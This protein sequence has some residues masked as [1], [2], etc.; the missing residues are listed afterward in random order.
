MKEIS[1]NDSSLDI[2][3][4]QKF[5]ESNEADVYYGYYQG[6]PIVFKKF[7]T[8]RVIDN[9]VKKIKILKER[10]KNTDNVVTADA[11]VYNHNNIIGYIMPF[12]YGTILIDSPIQNKK[13]S[14]ELLKQLS[15]DIKELHKYNIVLSDYENNTIITPDKKLIFIDHDNFGI[16]DLIIDSENKFLRYYKKHIKHID[17]H[18]DDY[19]MNLLTLATFKKIAF[20]YIDLYISVKKDK[21]IFKDEEINKIIQNT[22]NLNSTYNEGLI[23]DHINDKHDLKKL[24]TKRF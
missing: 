16:D 7:K 11:L 1:I 14:I 21:L 24:K 10:L 3:Y 2:R 5:E 6:K 8:H 15:A 18:F 22:I 4:D 19:Y 17:S 9:K 13:K 20:P 23:I 12:I